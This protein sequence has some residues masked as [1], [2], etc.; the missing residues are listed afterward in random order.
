MSL[1]DAIQAG[2][3][4]ANASELDDDEFGEVDEVDEAES[5][6][7]F[8]TLDEDAGLLTDEEDAGKSHLLAHYG[9]S[10]DPSW[11]PF[12]G[13][14][15]VAIKGLEWKIAPANN[16]EFT[17]IQDRAAR[18]YAEGRGRNRRIPTDRSNQIM[19]IIISKT[20]F[21]G[22]RGDWKIDEK[23]SSVLK[24]VPRW[25]A[26]KGS[27]KVVRRRMDVHFEVDGDGVLLDTQENRQRLLECL[28]KLADQA[29]EAAVELADQAGDNDDGEEAGN[30]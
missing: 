6:E 23:G 4:E 26:R 21:T 18:K 9:V 22:L 15:G 24:N 20:I 16:A 17:A 14:N 10:R 1:H 7:D 8:G 3:A 12:K 29:W 25:V 5:D 11:I 27:Q 30:S 19:P 28:P 13:P 2:P